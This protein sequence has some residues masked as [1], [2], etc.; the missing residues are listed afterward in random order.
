MTHHVKIQR[1]ED[2]KTYWVPI[3]IQRIETPNKDDGGNEPKRGYNPVSQPSNQKPINIKVNHPTNQP[4]Q[5]NNQ[6]DEDDIFPRK[7]RSDLYEEIESRKYLS[8]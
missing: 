6:D 4:Q 3:P 7:R 8:K 5:T 2:E 1:E